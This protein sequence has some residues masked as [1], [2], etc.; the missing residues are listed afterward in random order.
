MTMAIGPLRVD[1]V[2][3]DDLDDM[4]VLPGFA[5]DGIFWSLVTKL[6]G[7][8]TQW[9]RIYLQPNTVLPISVADASVNHSERHKQRGN[10]DET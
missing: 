9:R 5:N 6:P 4:P 10:Y 3:T 8:R 2:I 7:G 1:Y